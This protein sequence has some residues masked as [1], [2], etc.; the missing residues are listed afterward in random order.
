MGGEQRTKPG[1]VVFSSFTFT[2]LKRAFQA[3]TCL[4]S[5][6]G[7]SLLVSATA[8][9]RAHLAVSHRFPSA[10]DT[11]RPWSVLLFSSSARE[12]SSEVTYRGG[13]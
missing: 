5:E 3:K 11:E 12:V 8:G 13:K 1:L 10:L 7:L 2:N 6:A 4:L 9:P